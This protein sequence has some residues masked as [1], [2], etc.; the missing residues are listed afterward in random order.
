[1][2]KVAQIFG[3][4]RVSAIQMRYS[5][6]KGVLFTHP[7]LKPNPEQVES[8]KIPVI[9]FRESMQ[10]FDGNLDELSVIR[11][12]TFS[13][14]FLNRQVILLLNFLGVDDQFFLE[15]NS[16]S[17]RNLNVSETL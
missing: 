14:A 12:S 3:F 4:N 5:G 9:L 11:C 2:D 15:L 17:M 7:G 6:F 13:P 16:N 1:M 8:N 10:K